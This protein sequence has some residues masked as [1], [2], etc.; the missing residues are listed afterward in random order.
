MVRI[1]NFNEEIGEVGLIERN[2]I[3]TCDLN[4]HLHSLKRHIQKIF[5]K[6]NKF[7]ALK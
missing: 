4:L 1:V 7:H 3:K 5:V 2:L 6:S